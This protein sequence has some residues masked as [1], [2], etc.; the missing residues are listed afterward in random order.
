MLKIVRFK[1]GDMICG[2]YT[3]GE[4]QGSILV[5]GHDVPI[6][7]NVVILKNPLYIQIK[8]TGAKL[9]DLL[10]TISDDKELKFSPS[11]VM[12]LIEPS[13]AVRKTHEEV[14]AKSPVV[15]P[16]KKRLIV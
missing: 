12:T 5:N 15:T 6:L 16:K 13:A 1:N 9:I 10:S 11:E 2:E 8:D 4:Q 3:I 14:V 7:E